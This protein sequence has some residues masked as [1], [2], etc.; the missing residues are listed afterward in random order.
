MKQN[1]NTDKGFVTQMV[2]DR[3]YG[4]ITHYNEPKHVKGCAVTV[5]RKNLFL[6]VN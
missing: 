6:S 4:V 3:E 2:I 5:L 1:L